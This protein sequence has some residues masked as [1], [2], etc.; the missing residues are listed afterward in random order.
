MALV[1]VPISQV[2]QYGII[3]DLRPEEMPL[4]AWSDGQNVR[5]A[6]GKV[7][8]FLGHQSLWAP[9]SIAPYWA[10]QVPIATNVLWLYAGL[11][12]VYTWDGASHTNITRVSGGDYSATA[13]GNWTGCVLGGIPVINNGI[14][15]PQMWNPPLVATA[16]AALS[17]WQ[18][19][20]K[21]AALRAYKAFLVA[22]DITKASGNRYPH[23]VKWSHPTDPGAVPVSWDE[24][25]TTRDAGEYELAETPG[26]VLDCLPLRDTN[27]I[28][29]EDSVWGMQ[30]IGGGEVHRFS[31]IFTSF[32]A[33]SRRCIAYYEFGKHL[34]FTGDNVIVHDGQGAKELL[35]QRWQ[36]WLAGRI[37]STS[38]KRSFVVLNRSR[39]EVWVCFPESGQAFPSRA[40]VWNWK[41]D[42]LSD[43]IL[44]VVSHI[45]PG[46]TNPA[47]TTFDGDT[48]L[49]DGGPIGVFD[50][51]SYDPLNSG[52]VM[53][54]PLA[55]QL[56]QA[57]TTEAF[58]GTPI[59]SFI[60]RTGIGIPFEANRPPD[61]SS[62]KHLRRVWPKITGTAGGVVNVYLG[63][64]NNENAAVV[65]Q[66]AQGFT[67]GTTRY[68]DTM[69]P[70]RLFA[71]RVESTADVSWSLSGYDMEVS[72]G[73]RH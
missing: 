16:L 12:K 35:P 71:I 27:V 49:F 69:L 64:Q 70:G 47:D 65:W 48:P 42:T 44:P 68:I 30:Y 5:F 31:K 13:D 20:Y 53:C 61:I 14:D 24:T 28:Y 26:F 51:R 59:T 63:A 19:N 18:A 32:G 46:I 17:N 22:L 40:I 54:A 73:G 55:T 37:D 66:A 43:R 72:G 45:E 3:R 60:E 57:D 56:Y 11:A 1:T 9:P 38:Y 58:A 6:D 52:L 2:A 67:I 41:D 10:L 25:D 33:L 7:T 15:A 4:N 39:Y 21:C 8:K 23:M 34:V 36:R 50:E 62:M 29:K